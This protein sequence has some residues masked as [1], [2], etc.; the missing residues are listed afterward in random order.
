MA[1]ACLGAPG[2]V[3]DTG[4]RVCHA[5]LYRD[6]GQLNLDRPRVVGTGQAGARREQ[7][8]GTERFRR[9]DAHVTTVGRPTGVVRV[10]LDVRRVAAQAVGV[11]VVVKAIAW[12]VSSRGEADIA[13]AGVAKEAVVLKR[14]LP[15]IIAEGLVVAELGVRVPRAARALREARRR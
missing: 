3:R 8:S 11:G 15:D 4:A 10:A 7:L 13:V 12:V 14:I 1:L 5:G 2:A 9:K 6:W